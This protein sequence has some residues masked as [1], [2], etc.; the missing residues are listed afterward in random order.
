MSTKIQAAKIAL[1][2]GA[3]MAIVN[4]ADPGLL[5]DLLEGRP[6]G[7]LFLPGNNG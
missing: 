7:T 2:H 1:A 4:G 5:Y 6:A 3:P